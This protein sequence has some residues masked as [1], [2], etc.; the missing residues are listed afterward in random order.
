MHTMNSTEQNRSFFMSE[1]LYKT[2]GISGAG[3]ITIG[4]VS[5]TVGIVSGILLIIT[6]A[7][8]LKR[9]SEIIF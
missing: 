8:L 9:R 1:K 3:N 6:G 7:R 5:M 2:M 4:I